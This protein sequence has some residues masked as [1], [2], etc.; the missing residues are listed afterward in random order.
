MHMNSIFFTHVAVINTGSRQ[1]LLMGR[2][3]GYPK[4][5]P[6][7]CTL[8]KKFNRMSPRRCR[9]CRFHAGNAGSYYYHF[10]LCFRGLYLK[11]RFPHGERIH[12]TAPELAAMPIA[13]ITTLQT[14]YT[15]TDFLLFP[16]GRF[17]DKLRVCKQGSS[18][19]NEFHISLS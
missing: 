7:I 1:H 8:L 12:H 11:Y 15:W 2:D 4:L 5:S 19:C 18:Q 17:I 14:A 3:G 13:S 6:R 9:P 16:L 10:L